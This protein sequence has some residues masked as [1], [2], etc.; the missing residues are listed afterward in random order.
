[1]RKEAGMHPLAEVECGARAALETDSDV[2][3]IDARVAGD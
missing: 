2:R 1:V 3:I